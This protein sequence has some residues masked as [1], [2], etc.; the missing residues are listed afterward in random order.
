MVVRENNSSET[1]SPFTEIE[2]LGKI[3]TRI[4]IARERVWES[5]LR[6]Q[7]PL[8]KRQVVWRN[9]SEQMTEKQKSVKTCTKSPKNEHLPYWE[10]VV[11]STKKGNVVHIKRV[12]IGWNHIKAATCHT[13]NSFFK[14]PSQKQQWVSSRYQRTQPLAKMLIKYSLRSEFSAQFC[15]NWITSLFAGSDVQLQ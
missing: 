4:E 13:E 12:R 15:R 9:Y 11:V 6:E 10:V 7:S 1:S 3:I 8:I 2:C 5:H 14:N